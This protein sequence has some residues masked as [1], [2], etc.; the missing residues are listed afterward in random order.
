MDELELFLD[1]SKPIKKKVLECGTS[2][3]KLANTK[4]IGSEP[5]L[6]HK[7]P[8]TRYAREFVRWLKDKVWKVN[9]I[10]LLH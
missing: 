10:S 3:A 2:R 1:L 6:K 4:M 5:D 9:S 8:E 7:K